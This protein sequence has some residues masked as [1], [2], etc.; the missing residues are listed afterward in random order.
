MLGDLS[1]G[2]PAC[3]HL[4]PLTGP[5]I[6]VSFQTT[7]VSLL[8]PGLGAVGKVQGMPTAGHCLAWGHRPTL[9]RHLPL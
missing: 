3:F 9:S 6:W 7:L 5:S 8:T 1:L 4:N 2:Y